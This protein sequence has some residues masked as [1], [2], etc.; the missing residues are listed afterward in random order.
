[1]CMIDTDNFCEVWVETRH[2]AIR[3]RQICDCCSREIP[4]GGEYVKNFNK[5]EGQVSYGKMC[6]ECERIRDEFAKDHDGLLWPPDSI[7]RMLEE[8]IGG[9][10]DDES[11]KWEPM[12]EWIKAG[13][14]TV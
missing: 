4:I 14:H 13:S 6:L 7:R 9:D 5:F 1:M 11:R 8:C 3:K 10:E 2:K 12:L